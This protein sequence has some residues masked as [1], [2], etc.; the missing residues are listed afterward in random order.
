MTQNGC[1]GPVIIIIDVYQF[2]TTSTIGVSIKKYLHNTHTHTQTNTHTHTHKMHIYQLVCSWYIPSHRMPNQFMKITKNLL[3][4][5]IVIGNRVIVI[6]RPNFFYE[7]YEEIQYLHPFKDT[8][9]MCLTIIFDVTTWIPCTLL[10]SDN[11]S[12]RN[13]M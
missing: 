12:P 6:A 1:C 3:F 7:N 8:M 4:C 11:I 5:Y 13:F 2:S 9:S 10:I